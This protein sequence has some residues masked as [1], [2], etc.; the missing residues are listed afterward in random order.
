MHRRQA[1]PHT[2]RCIEALSSFDHR[3]S[4][5]IH[6]RADSAHCWLI[7]SGGRGL[8]ASFSH[9]VCLSVSRRALLGGHRAP[10]S[11][12]IRSSDLVD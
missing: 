2:A 12:G 5:N 4:M 3:V 8:C 6:R 9:P 7:N 1:R 10:R 11:V